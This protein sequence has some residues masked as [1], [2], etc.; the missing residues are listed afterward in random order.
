MSYEN[1]HIVKLTEDQVSQ[2]KVDIEKAATDHL[3]SNNVFSALNHYTEDARI[4][5][6]G[7]LYESPQSLKVDLQSFYD[8]LTEIN[9][10][11]YTDLRI[12]VLGHGIAHL[13]AKFAWMSSD[14]NAK[15]IQIEGT[16]S[17]LYVRIDGQW[18]MSFRHES[19][20]PSE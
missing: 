13:S 18:K 7:V 12:N 10:A 11:S 9:D 6:N 14:I 1:Q 4:M 16:W 19:F 15:R 8:R 17:A 2:I 3:F 20:A 5:S